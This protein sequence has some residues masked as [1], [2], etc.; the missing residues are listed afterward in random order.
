MKV[1][2]HNKGNYT[3]IHDCVCYGTIEMSLKEFIKA[4]DYLYTRYKKAKT[5]TETYTRDSLYNLFNTHKIRE[6]IVNKSLDNICLGVCATEIL[7][8]KYKL[9]RYKKQNY[10]IVIK[11]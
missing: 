8:K 1:I 9:P 2:N 11:N 6:A 3:Y 5:Y 7:F 10:L 4:Y